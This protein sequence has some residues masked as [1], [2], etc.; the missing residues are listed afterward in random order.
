M[1]LIRTGMS[2]ALQSCCRREHDSA[3]R[4]AG[5]NLRNASADLIQTQFSLPILDSEHHGETMLASPD[6]IH[7]T[8]SSQPH[9]DDWISADAKRR[10]SQLLRYDLDRAE[11]R[12]PGRAQRST[13]SRTYCLWLKD[14]AEAVTA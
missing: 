9:R 6:Q 13:Q 14:D 5:D 8:S 2:L 7:I 11:S 1:S 12:D 4:H 10:A 3:K